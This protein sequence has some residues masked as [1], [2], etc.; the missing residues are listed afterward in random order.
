MFSASI[1][2]KIF[3]KKDTT[4]YRYNRIRN[5]WAF[6]PEKN[7]YQTQNSLKDK[8][9][10]F[11]VFSSNDAK[12]KSYTL[13]N[14]YIE[15]E[16]VA[17]RL[18]L[19]GYAMPGRVYDTR[20]YELIV[21][22]P[23]G[24]HFSISHDVFLNAVLESGLEPGGM[25]PGK[26]I[27]VKFAKSVRP[28]Q[29]ESNLYKAVLDLEK[30]K[31]KK[32]IKIKNMQVGDV[33]A[34]GAGNL[35]L[36]LGFINTEAMKVVNLPPSAEKHFYSKIHSTKD[37]LVDFG[38]RY[39]EKTLLS[40]W[41]DIG[42]KN[43]GHNVSPS[44]LA[45]EVTKALSGK[46]HYRFVVKNQHRYND[47]VSDKRTI[48]PDDVIQKVRNITTFKVHE[49]IENDKKYRANPNMYALQMT[50]ATVP[51]VWNPPDILR[52]FDALR[53]AEYSYILNMV[54]FGMKP[55]RSDVCK[56]FD[57]WLVKNPKTKTTK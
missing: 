12:A 19:V 47:K 3:F 57:K 33:Y 7:I 35:G 43:E 10:K 45:Q 14:G 17:I 27:F 18:K 44:Y 39:K 37:P 21:A 6:L 26:Y 24:I 23:N 38:I 9:Y 56:I 36:F 11:N 34:T 1:P 32:K 52:H 48:L 25:L 41:M 13:K 5:D 20:R 16:N 31:E 15:E 51:T 4:G 2:E 55:V 8:T 29:I 54:P 28:V 42:N 40:L 46:L 22:T 50:K 49:M 30:D 53:V